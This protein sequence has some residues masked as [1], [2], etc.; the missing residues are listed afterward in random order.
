MK[1]KTNKSKLI[2]VIKLIAAKNFNQHKSTLTPFVTQKGV[3]MSAFTQAVTVEKK[4]R[5]RKR[6]RGGN[7]SPS[8][9]AK[10]KAKIQKEKDEFALSQ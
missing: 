10:K 1:L 6:G 8:E 4:K 5:F 3:T 7:K 2:K 9:H